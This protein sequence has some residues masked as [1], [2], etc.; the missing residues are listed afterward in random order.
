VPGRDIMVQSWY[1]GG[2]SVWDFTDSAAPVEIAYFD[3]GPVDAEELVLAGY[4]SSYWYDGRIYATEI[5]R[6]LDVFTLAPS[7]FLSENEIAAALLAR[8]AGVFNPQQQFPVTWPAEPVVGRAYVDQLRR[9]QSSV[10][11]ATL[12]E[13]SAVLDLVAARLAAVRSDPE[14]AARAHALAR[15]LE[16][17]GGDAITAK[18]KKGLAETLTGLAA[19]LQ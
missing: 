16:R 10:S 11:A 15:E 14:L 5:L 8:Q 9:G 3:R 1:Q 18:R 12:D 17:G 2:I 4:W 13:A 7:A 6:G 19:R